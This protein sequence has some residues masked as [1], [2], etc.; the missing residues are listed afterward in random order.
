MN[1]RHKNWEITEADY[2]FYEAANLD[3]CDAFTK[4]AKTIRELIIEINEEEE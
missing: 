2:G 4:Y 1:I 3:D